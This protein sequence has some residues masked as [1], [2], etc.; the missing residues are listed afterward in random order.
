MSTT[1][2]NKFKGTCWICRTTVAAGAGTLGPKVSGKWTTRC[3]AHSDAA[4]EAN[5]VKAYGPRGHNTDDGYDA[6]KDAA[7]ENGTWGSRHH[8]GGRGSYLGR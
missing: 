4:I 2:T 8:Q 5:Y 1:R 6:M 7:C 3:V